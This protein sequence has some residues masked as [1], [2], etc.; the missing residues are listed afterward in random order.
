MKKIKWLF[1]ALFVFAS[2]AEAQEKILTI[3]DIFGDQKTRVQFGGR[4]LFVQWNKDG[5]FRQFKADAD[6]GGQLFRINSLTGDAQPF[7]D[8]SRLEAA[9]VPAGIN[10]ETAKKRFPVL[11]I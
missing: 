8:K 5:T 4:P 10:A 11:K 1:V 9:L 6:T 2:F 3:D 7:L